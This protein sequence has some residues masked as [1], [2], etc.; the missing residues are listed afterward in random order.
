MGLTLCVYCSSSSAVAAPFGELADRFGTLLG[1]RGHTLVYGGASVGS[2]GRL[3]RAAQA[4]GARVVGVIPEA[5]VGVEVANQDCDELVVTESLRARKAVMDERAEAF[6]A[7][8]GGFG[9][10]EELLE[11]LTAKQLGYHRRPVVL[12]D[13]DEFWQPLVAWASALIQARFAK[14]SFW[15]LFALTS[16]VDVALD[17]CEQE[18]GPE[19]ERKWF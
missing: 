10:L 15:D 18:D 1:Q 13:H 7:L 5:M 19:P 12:V 17:L 6:V 16:E 9:T 2:M 11:V 8:P 14:P 4:A 3:A